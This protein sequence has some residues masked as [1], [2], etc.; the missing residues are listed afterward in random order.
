MYVPPI[1]QNVNTCHFS[2]Y[3]GNCSHNHFATHWGK[4]KKKKQHSIWHKTDSKAIKISEEWN[5]GSLGHG[6][7]QPVS[8]SFYKFHLSLTCGCLHW[9]YVSE[10]LSKGTQLKVSLCYH[11]G[12]WV[13][14][15]PLTPRCCLQNQGILQG[16]WPWSCPKEIWSLLSFLWK[17]GERVHLGQV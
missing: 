9:D 7:F 10:T 16:E 11:K 12:D 2:L 5:K 14:G 8:L 1:F 4:K 6:D 15:N 13:Q 17:L 3:M